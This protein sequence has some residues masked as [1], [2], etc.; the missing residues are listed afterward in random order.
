LTDSINHLIDVIFSNQSDSVLE[1]KYG[2]IVISGADDEIF[3]CKTNNIF[4]PKD[5]QVFLELDYKSNA[6]FVIGLY[7]NFAQTTSKSAIIYLNKKE[8]WNKTYIS[9]SEE[10]SSYGNTVEDYNIFI[11]MSRD[12]SLFTNELLIDNLRLVY[13]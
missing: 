3:E 6:T 1:K 7:A 10:I 13:E 12:T 2:K 11:G 8:E 9:L 5:R 4:L